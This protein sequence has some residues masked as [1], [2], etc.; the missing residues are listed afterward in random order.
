MHPNGTIITA[1]CVLLWFDKKVNFFQFSLQDSNQDQRRNQ[2]Q[3][4]M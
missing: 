1:Y 3:I 2:D 4:Q